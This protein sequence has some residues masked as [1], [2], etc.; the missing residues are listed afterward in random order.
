MAA[1]NPGSALALTWAARVEYY[2]G[3]YYTLNGEHE[4]KALPYYI[5]S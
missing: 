3:E 2:V 5:I 1:E 4:T